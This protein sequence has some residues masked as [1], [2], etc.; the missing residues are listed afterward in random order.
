MA[1]WQTEPNWLELEINESSILQEAKSASRVL[2]RLKDMGTIRSGRGRV[3]PD[4][5]RPW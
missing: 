5:R 3:S 4:R 2:A 1:A